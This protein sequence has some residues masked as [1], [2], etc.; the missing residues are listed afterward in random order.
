MAPPKINSL[1]PILIVP[2]LG[3]SKA[4]MHLRSVVLPEPE[5]QIKIVV[6]PFLIC[7]SIPFNIF[8]YHQNSCVN[9]LY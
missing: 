9:F 5:G 6:S 3:I 4:F 1:S 7:K 2:S 8:H